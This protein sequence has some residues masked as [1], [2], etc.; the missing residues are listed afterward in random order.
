MA[1]FPEIQSKAQNELD[2]VIG[3]ERL[4]SYEDRDLLPYVQAVVLE[5][6][7]WLPVLPLG[8]LHRLTRDD[9]YGGYFL[10]AGTAFLP[11]SNITFVAQYV[12]S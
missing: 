1:M 11:V 2:A 3:R 7:R 12:Y 10:P 9:Y 8:V 5:C 4:P 6:T